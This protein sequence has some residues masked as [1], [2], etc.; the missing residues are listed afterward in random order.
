MIGPRKF[1][2][3][4]A[5]PLMAAAG[6]AL[7]ALGACSENRPFERESAGAQTKLAVPASLTP[8]IAVRGI[9]GA[10]DEWKLAERVAEALR[11]RDIPASAAL[12]TRSAYVL[13]GEMRP[14]AERHGRSRVEVVWNLY[15]GVGKKVGEV[16]QM[17]AVPGAVFK[18]PNEGVIAAMADAAAESIAPLVPSSSL[19]LADGTETGERK[20]N[21]RAQIEDRDRV[22]GVGKM[23]TTSGVARNLLAPPKRDGK[24]TRAETGPARPAPRTT[25]PNA[26]AP[27]AAPTPAVRN[28]AAP[29]APPPADGKAIT[30]VGRYQGESALSRNLLRP[31]A[32]AAKPLPRPQRA[33]PQPATPAAAPPVQPATRENPEAEESLSLS[34]L[35][36]PAADTR[37]APTRVAPQQH[38]EAPATRADVAERPRPVAE[39]PAPRRETAP[40]RQP[41]PVQYAERP[42]RG[43]FQFWIQVGSHKDEAI[44]RAEWQKIQSGAQ[45]VL[46]NAG[47]RIQRADLGARGVYFRIQVGPFASQGEAGQFCAQLRARSVECFLAPPERAAASVRPPEEA[48]AKPAAVAPQPKPAAKAAEPKPVAKPAEPKPVAKPAEP[49]PAAKPPDAKPIAKPAEAKPAPAERPREAAAAPKKPEAEA[50]A[51]PEQ[52]PEAKP[53]RNASAEKPDAPLSTAPGLPGVL[54]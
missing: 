29:S 4:R 48:P 18:T 27:K 44:A 31:D 22:T 17:A 7:L 23:P 19:E 42:S 54:D 1:R 25:A 9:D 12:R 49:A 13:K 33:T 10:P 3:C 5:L 30:A 6:V 34:A 37:R 46:A 20:P 26:A 14:G 52:K 28:A 35:P 24:A 53:P 16:T 41:G 45:A 8:P 43:N 36:E 2:T 15:D 11:S 39:S 21:D 38:A 50:P 32:D 40:D 51:L 47:N